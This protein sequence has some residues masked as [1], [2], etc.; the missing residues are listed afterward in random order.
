MAQR[1]CPETSLSDAQ[2][3]ALAEGVLRVDQDRD[4]AAALLKKT[5]A[6]EPWQAAVSSVGTDT[7]M[8]RF[9]RHRL[10]YALG[11]RRS[12]SELIPDRDHPQEQP[13]VY[14]ERGVSEIARLWAAAWVGNELSG[15]SFVAQCALL[16]RLFDN[17]PDGDQD[18]RHTWDVLNT[19]RTDFYTLLAKCAR[20][21]G[22][23]A[24]E[25]LAQ[26][27]ERVFIRSDFRG[28][29][30]VSL[31]TALVAVGASHDWGRRVLARVE[32][33][34]RAHEDAEP[35]ERVSWRNDVARAW[36]LLGSRDR[37]RGLVG[38]ALRLS[39]GTASRKDYQ[40][41]EWIKWM[42]KANASDPER[43]FERIR[44]VLGTVAGMADYAAGR[45]TESAST[46]LIRGAM[47]WSPIGTVSLSSTLAE[48]GAASYVHVLRTM[49]IEG[50]KRD[51]AAS[52]VSVA[53]VAHMLIPI[54]T[55]GD[56]ELLEQ[57]LRA[58]YQHGGRS[59]VEPCVS[60]L[61]YAID[62]LALPSAR[63][64]WTSGLHEGLLACDLDPS[65]FGLFSAGDV[66]D[67][68][69]A[70]TYGKLV[71]DDGTAMS[72]EAV[73]TT[74]T[75][76]A[77]LYELLDQEADSSYFDWASVV[78]DVAASLDS[79]GCVQLSEELRRRFVDG[80]SHRRRQ[81]SSLLMVA[82][83]QIQLGDSMGAWESA[84]EAA[85]RAEPIGWDRHWD[86]GSKRKAYEM[87]V[88]I[89]PI[90]GRRMAFES[91]VSDLAGGWWRPTSVALNLRHLAPLVCGQ[92]VPAVEVWNIVCR[93]LAVLLPSERSP[94]EI[95]RDAPG[96]DVVSN[97]LT[98][99]LFDWL[100][101]RVPV[102]SHGAMR[103]CVDLLL[104]RNGTVQDALRHRLDADHCDATTVA[105]LMVLQAV[106]RGE[107]EVVG[108]FRKSILELA[109]SPDQGVRW[110]AG[111]V[112]SY[113]GADGVPKARE[114]S[115]LHHY[116]GRAVIHC[117]PQL[118]GVP[119][120][121]HTFETVPDSLDPYDT[122]APWT[123]EAAAIARRAGL[124]TDA[125][126]LRVVDYMRELLPEGNWNASAERGLR[127]KLAAGEL[128][129]PF[130]R[131][132]AA[133]A[134]RALH[135]VVRELSE[136]GRLSGRLMEELRREMRHYDPEM[137]VFRPDRRPDEI[138]GV[139]EGTFGTD[140]VDEVS[141]SVRWA[142]IRQLGDWRVVGERTTIRPAGEGGPQE[143]RQVGAF[144]AS[145]G[146]PPTHMDGSNLFARLKRQT[147]ESYGGVA[148]SGASC[149][150]L[151]SGA[152]YDT[153]GDEWMA[154]DPVMAR[155]LGWKRAEG[156]LFAW[157]MGGTA[158]GKSVWWSDGVVEQSM[159]F[160]KK[161]EVA[162][163][164][165]V[166][167][168]DEAVSELE[169]DVGAMMYCGSWT[170]SVFLR[171]GKERYSRTVCFAG[172]WDD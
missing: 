114:E 55:D 86:G 120:P 56:S 146:F 52:Q 5:H 122:I 123:A 46:E 157:E 96:E 102:M 27:F 104:D 124:P 110:A 61:R 48:T 37:A 171:G 18:G 39:A 7:F 98:V 108:S 53:M 43:S 59:R 22:C 88:C 138:A 101:G 89:D 17:R 9:R 70:N 83:R 31:V 13:L 71:L 25:A 115:V 119:E 165:L 54:A 160:W 26:E 36:I 135:H 163:G 10:M 57:L 77:R 161:C 109:H 113:I 137:L 20:E 58:V 2:R 29:P 140:W 32:P 6:L 41:D 111:E 112:A 85:R 97:A 15:P 62:V 151:H 4:R 87:L 49:V 42:R 92:E 145:R 51:N 93:Y 164:W 79:A 38:E 118:V 107:A 134:R 45:M 35:S 3:I 133:L 23:E 153:P 168:A 170:R 21:H 8:P 106:G 76:P 125:V 142:R 90:Q 158:K 152:A 78:S 80:T 147:Q 172:D 149:V 75:S 129:L 131:P 127:E 74:I 143:V 68:A 94:L 12:A 136:G 148:G 33:V 50:L 63:S 141:G 11:E 116:E 69:S 44:A 99:S 82:E 121:D 139:A 47:D 60:A 67:V 65:E 91:L 155:R 64:A 100:D 34:Y 144:P 132:R 150:V 81:T 95:S 130:R 16:L 159:E 30:L 166:V 72:P 128:K 66:K 24:V 14:L 28:W 156:G 1:A 117:A 169:R 154:L 73:A 105:I 162:E 167:V 40:L 19:G 126:V 84:H 103:A